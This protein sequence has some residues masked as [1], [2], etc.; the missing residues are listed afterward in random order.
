MTKQL[1]I[2]EKPSQA[3]DIAKILGCNHRQEGYLLNQD[4]SVLVSWC[5]GHLLELEGP[6]YY[7]KNIKPWR[8]DV[9]PII[10]EEWKLAV[11]PASKKQ[12]AILKKLLKETQTVVIATDAD[13]EGES[14]AREIL[15]LCRFKGNIK[16]LWLSAL[17]DSSIKKAIA[18]MR[19]GK[20]TEHLYEAALGRQRADW[21][22]G[23]NMTMATSVLFSKKGEGVLSVGRVQTPTL[24][25][26]VDRDATIEN[27]KPQHYIELIAQFT[28]QN[29]QSFYAK[30]QTPKDTGDE[31]GRCL[32]KQVVITTASKIRGKEGRIAQFEDKQKSQAA[33]LCLSLSQLQKVA[34]SRF[35]LSAQ[36][37]L[38]TAQSLYETHKAITYPR[39]DCGYLPIS[40]FGDSKII[41]KNLKKIN[42]SLSALIERCDLDFKS[43][44]W[45]DRKITAHHAMIPTLNE[46]IQIA[47]MNDDERKIY[48]LVCGYYVAQF[49]GDYEYT[50][51]SVNVL[52]E[53][54]LFKASSIT[55]LKQGWKNALK[56]TTENDVENDNLN[57]IPLLQQNEKIMHTDEEILEKQTQPP[58]RFTEGTL[59]D[60]M[61][62]IGK[63]VS[64][65]K[66]KKI[67][68]ETAGIGTEA[69]RANIIETLFKRGYI[70]KK[71][72]QIFAMAKG[73]QL[74]SLLPLRICDPILTATM[75]QDL[76][77]VSQG[78]LKLETF[79]SLLKESLHQML[80]S[81]QQTAL[82]PSQRDRK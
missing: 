21:L 77:F 68:K 7:C 74:I 61:K 52:C 58:A 2:C 33:P 50:Q 14:I 8:M 3:R 69:T 40:Q 47:K 26:I 9:L 28:T 67:L 63:H 46:H 45:D 10:P 75:E 71:G 23:M 37:T 1:F 55:P 32:N 66:F 65:E 81:L 38:D 22:M 12:F 27:F 56:N 18:D 16:R 53:A 5:F 29:Q 41:L 60:A 51:R 15:H 70:E 39:T 62:T 25:L 76:D 13:R 80:A 64:D 20:T 19:E 73:R 36:R 79:I 24:K 72:K 82:N 4:N 57:L 34:S 17:D 35:G 43:L 6:S 59:I 31:E 11:K 49:L 30:W 44:V 48:D 42:E 78:Q 54:E